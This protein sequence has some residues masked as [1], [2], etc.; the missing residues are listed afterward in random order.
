MSKRRRF[1]PN[2]VRQRRVPVFVQPFLTPEYRETQPAYVPLTVVTQ[3][4]IRAE[5]EAKAGARGE[6]RWRSPWDY[7]R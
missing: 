6:I 5:R 2:A 4:E 7:R 3:H 1:D